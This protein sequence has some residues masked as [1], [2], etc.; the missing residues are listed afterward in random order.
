MTHASNPGTVPVERFGKDHWSLF[1]YVAGLAIDRRSAD[2]A[3]LRSDG[4]CYPTRLRAGQPAPVTG[5]NDYDCLADLE[6]AGLIEALPGLV[7]RL[8]PAGLRMYAALIEHKQNRGAFA[9]FRPPPAGE[10]GAPVC[11]CGRRMTT[12]R[13][14]ELGTVECPLRVEQ[15]GH[16]S[17]VVRP[18]SWPVGRE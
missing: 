16:G 1:A 10:E 15:A 9:T 13:D 4:L 7:C 17:G 11:Q 6:A 12:W 2:P 5:H 3:R 14:P 8:T 18:A